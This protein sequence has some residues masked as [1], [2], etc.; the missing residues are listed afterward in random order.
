MIS[1]K[2]H[3]KCIIKGCKREKRKGGKHCNTCSGRLWRKNNPMRAAYNNLKSN[4]AK[5]NI[6]FNL[7]FEEF[8]KFC[9]KT[10]YIQGKGRTKESYSIDRKEPTIGYV[11]DNL[12]ILTVSDNAKKKKM[13]YYDWQTKYAIVQ[14]HTIR[15]TPDDPF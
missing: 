3:N 15:K 7:T 14:D 10:Q 11:Y 12:Q 13:L 2:N 6:E 8:K 1:K 5:R 4:S 9:V